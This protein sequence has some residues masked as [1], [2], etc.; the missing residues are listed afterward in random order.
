MNAI[1]DAIKLIYG[2]MLLFNLQREL[3]LCIIIPFG[4]INFLCFG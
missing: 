4:I 3:F 1:G 2:G